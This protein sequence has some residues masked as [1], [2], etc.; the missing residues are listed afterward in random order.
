MGVP[1]AGWSEGWECLEQG[2]VRGRSAQGSL[3]VLH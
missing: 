1:R 3:F 2:G